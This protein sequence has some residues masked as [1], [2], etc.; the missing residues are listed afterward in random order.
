MP[1]GTVAAPLLLERLTSTPPTAAAAARVTVPVED[2]P[3]V[4]RV[5]LTA[6]PARVAVP[7]PAGLMA[8]D[9]ELEFAEVAVIR[10]DV[11]L[12]TDEVVI[13]NVPFVWP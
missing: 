6:T 1:T 2:C 9:A 5:G 10:A 8:S 13:V 11:E 3:A 4:T 12:V 7:G